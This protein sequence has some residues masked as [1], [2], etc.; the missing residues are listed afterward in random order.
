MTDQLNEKSGLDATAPEAAD[1]SRLDASA[2]DREVDEAFVTT[3]ADDVFDE[4]GDGVD[5]GAAPQYGVGPF[6]VREVAL[7]GA[8]LIAF[9]VSFFPVSVT[10]LG[11]LGPMQLTWN[12][13]W[14]SGLSW[15]LTIGLPTIAVF[16]LALRRLS[17][18]GIR[19]VGSL[20][21]DQF[22]SV[23]FSVATLVW[24]QQVWET[25]SVAAESGIWVRSWVMWVEFFLMLLG[26]VLTVFA[27]FIPPF[28]E[29]FDGRPEVPAHR[30]ARPVRAVSPRPAREPRVFA[31]PAPVSEAEPVAD[32]PYAGYDAA[33]P[34]ASAVAANATPAEPAPADDD[35]TGAIDPLPAEPQPSPR[36]QAFWAL[37][38]DERDV[39][40]EIGI[41]VF[42]IG[43][44][45]WAL[46]IEDRGEA[47][48][49]RHE[50]GRIGYLH[51][52]SGVT[53]G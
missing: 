41:P 3:Q 36:Q 45:A 22:A 7:G 49:V 43:P 8:W 28:D 42:R 38:P 4:P 13:V 52:V 48:V 35:V 53:R 19:R 47:F 24:L 40:D 5:E 50:D 20:G 25:V 18:D 34:Y 32:D 1:E 12:S 16:L 31:E 11:N 46:V 44:T 27:P 10:W 26:V 15:I 9:I 37:A 30:N 6:S 23:A 14:S 33:D 51:D 17:P 29:D 39:V 2:T 21:V